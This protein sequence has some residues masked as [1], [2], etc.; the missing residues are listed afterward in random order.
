MNIDINSVSFWINVL[1]GVLIIMAFMAALFMMRWRN[2]KKFE[3]GDKIIA[4]IL[5]ENAPRSY[6]IAG[7][8]LGK[9]KSE[10]W[11]PD[12]DGP[13]Y[14]TKDEIDHIRYPAGSL[15]RFTQV[16]A[17]VVPWRR[18]EANPINPF[19]AKPL[20]STKEMRDTK[21][22]DDWLGA[23]NE[24][25]QYAADFAKTMKQMASSFIKPS[26]FWL[27][28]GGLAFLIGAVAYYG[29]AFVFEPLLRAWG[30]G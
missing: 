22:D 29:Y 3:G 18:G 20:C 15:F 24:M 30:L 28:I 1:G 25:G 12:G 27:A 14:F 6:Y 13:Y 7:V 11:L 16:D 23:A 19:K 21:I 26:H 4:E 8:K 17:P 2:G 10:A 9:D 5:N